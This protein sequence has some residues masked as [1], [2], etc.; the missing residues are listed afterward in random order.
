MKSQPMSSWPGNAVAKDAAPSAASGRRQSVSLKHDQTDYLLP[1]PQPQLATA[2]EL[3]TALDAANIRYGIVQDLG[4][5]PQALAGR[6]DI[7][8][9]LDRQDYR[10]FCAIMARLHGLR[11]VSL[12]CYDNVCDGREDWFIPDFSSSAY[13]HI[14]LHVGIRVGWEFRK[15]YLAFDYG[16]ISQWER[17]SF[18]GISIPVVSSMDEIRLALG[19]FAFRLWA[20]PWTRWVAIPGNWQDDIARLP[21]S[22]QGESVIQFDG[23]RNSRISCRI[24]PGV[25]GIEVHRGDLARL[26]RSIRHRCGFSSGSALTDATVH[27]IRK[28]SYLLLRVLEQLLPGGVPSKRRASAGGLV[29]AL[30]APDGLGKTTQTALL[31]KVFAWKFGCEQVYVGTGEGNGWWLRKGLQKLLAPRKGQFKALIRHERKAQSGGAKSKVM[32]SGLALWG[33]LIAIERYFV[34]KRAHRWAARGLIV[35]CDRWPQTLRKGYLDGPM[36][37][38]NLPAIPGLAALARFEEWLYRKM[39]ECKPDLTLHLVSDFAVS[40]SRKPG[41]ISKEG[42]EARMSLMAELRARD[43]HIRVVDASADTETI[44][45]NLFKQIWL[46]L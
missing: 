31:K 24:R 4:T 26:R 3:F 2:A 11:S 44:N 9:L 15:R 27:L 20:W 21:S 7:D 10:A 46:L 16:S 12:S 38:S 29:V 33:I 40:Q 42:F 1:L 39:A 13:L 43:E 6:D 25:D 37:P 23:G 17:L 34:V 18:D 35:V 28:V 14:D 30:V 5:L 8:M 19:R 22:M 36:I 45:R 41:E 32:A